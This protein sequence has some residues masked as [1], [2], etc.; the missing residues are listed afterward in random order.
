MKIPDDFAELE[1][2]I[3]QS[4]G[5]KS[6][7][8]PSMK[9]ILGAV[10]ALLIL[11]GVL[12]SYYTVEPEGEAVVTRFGAVSSVQQPGLH[13][14]LPFGIDR[15][16]FVPT[17]RVL[18]EEFG[19]RSQP[20]SGRGSRFQQTSEDADEALMLTGDLNVINVEW[21]VQYRIQRPEQYLFQVQDPT[22][23]I[24]DVSESVMRRVVGNRLGSD[25]LTVGRASI[26]EEVKREMNDI[27]DSY[28]LGIDVT[29]VELQDV[30]PPDRVAPA[31]N[32]VN[33]ARQQKERAV[34]LAEKERNQVIPKA[35]GEAQQTISEAEAYALER[36]NKAKGET[37][38]FSALLEEYKKS[39]AI[40]RQR[41]FLEMVDSVLPNVESLYVLDENTNGP[42]PLLDLQG[43][44]K[45]G[46]R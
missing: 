39:E 16:Y 5:L 17:K 10:L 29:A 11:I 21:V 44:A 14:K 26:S 42:L 18:K 19:F 2:R 38:R 31:F 34:N 30:T 1:R 28:N 43:A 22:Q 25:V 9:L 41:L 13:F 20:N 45:K 23:S 37:A 46:G 32:A 4:G 35:R 33:E 27:L 15:V 40:T 6:V 12:S 36:I 24:R 3:Q 8:K 7:A